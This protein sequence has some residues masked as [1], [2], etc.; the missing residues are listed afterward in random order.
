MAVTKQSCTVPS[1]CVLGPSLRQAKIRM[2][3]NNIFLL[4]N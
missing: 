3:D 1:I 2:M 4:G